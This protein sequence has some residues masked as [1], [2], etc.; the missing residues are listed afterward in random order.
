MAWARAGETCQP[1]ATG[2]HSFSSAVLPRHTHEGHSQE[3]L[4]VESTRNARMPITG[5]GGFPQAAILT[6]GLMTQSGWKLPANHWAFG[7]RG[8]SDHVDDCYDSHDLVPGSGDIRS[9]TSALEW[10]VKK[11][12]AFWSG[13]FPYVRK[14]PTFSSST[15]KTLLK[16]QYISMVS[17]MH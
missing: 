17:D 10:K 5:I 1:A 7:V 11:D 16:W 2:Y 13:Y 14:E 15:L 12:E 9:L 3:H 4:E 6:C 8:S